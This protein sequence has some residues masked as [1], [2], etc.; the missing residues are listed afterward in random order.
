MVRQASPPRLTVEQACRMIGQ[1]KG[2]VRTKGIIMK[3]TQNKSSP[4]VKGTG[5]SSA[6]GIG[7]GT[8][9]RPGKGKFPIQSSAPAN[10]R[11]LGRAPSGYLK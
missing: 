3:S 10:P 1:P 6:H 11:E 4:G 8:S 9:S 2:I 7:A 5:G